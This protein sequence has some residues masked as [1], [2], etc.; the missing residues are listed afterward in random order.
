MDLALTPA[1]AALRE[2][3]RRF[4]V[5]VLQPLEVDARARRRPA[6]AAEGSASCVGSVI[7]AGL[8][9]GAFPRA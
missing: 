2:R 3:A 6:A 1:Q 9:G 5:E 4:V 8:A 7:A